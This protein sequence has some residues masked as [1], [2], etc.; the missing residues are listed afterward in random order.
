[1]S[2]TVAPIV[3]KET[4]EEAPRKKDGV[5]ISGVD[6]VLMRFAQCCNPV[7]GDAIVGYISRGVGITVHRQDCPNVTNME[8]ERLINVYWD[9]EEEKP[10]EAGIFVIAK[11]ERGVL[12][13]TAQAI[14]KNEVNISGL[15]MDTTVDGKAKLKFT[16]EVRNATQLYKLIED[17]RA[18]PAIL[19]VIRESENDDL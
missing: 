4:K 16:V 11:N 6:G 18:M 10:Y 3:P 1:E 9:G 5:S 15:V 13:H 14:A 17:I 12:A 8:I 7:P 2:V 19:E